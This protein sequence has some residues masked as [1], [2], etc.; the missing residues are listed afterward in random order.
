[1]AGRFIYGASRPVI[2]PITTAQQVA[3]TDLVGLS[4]GNLT[5]AQ[6]LSWPSAVA[7][8]SAPTV[9][10]GAVNI[11]TPLTHSATGVK[12]SFNFP[13][14]EGALSPAGS[15]TP[16]AGAALMVAG[17]TLPSPAVSINYY[18]ETAAGSG[19]FQLA[20]TGHGETKM[21]TSYGVGQT[22][23]ATPAGSGS[24]QI[25]QYQFTQIF[26]GASGQEKDAN[27]AQIT[28]AGLPNVCRV[29]C[30][31]YLSYDLDTSYTWNVGD[32]FGPAVNGGGN[33][34]QS[35]VLS[36]LG[37]NPALAQLAVAT[38]A[39]AGVAGTNAKVNLLSTISK[40]SR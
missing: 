15:A 24:L 30:S 10:D 17:I 8:P 18:V 27:V 16:T 1:M 19:N 28:G 4:S 6:D 40:A 14:G 22:P 5:R 9:T 38:A 20:A 13:W 23:P 33:G 25:A 11:G 39:E 37:S 21:L 3:I 32:F 7:T 34:L 29:D 35:Q 26:L 36:W 12:I 31:G 2:V